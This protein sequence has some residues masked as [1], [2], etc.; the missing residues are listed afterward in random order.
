MVPHRTPCLALSRLILRFV[1]VVACLAAAS[2]APASVH[3]QAFSLSADASSIPIRTTLHLAA[4]AGAGAT[5]TV[6]FFDGRS[7]L[8]TVPLSAQGTAIYATAI[9]GSGIHSLGAVY[10]GDSSH[11]PT[12]A[13]TNPVSVTTVLPP[14]FTLSSNQ[15]SVYTGQPLTL[16]A[17]G[18]PPDATGTLT[19]LDAGVPIASTTISRTSA[20][21]YLS[22]GD[23]IPGGATLAQTALS[24]PSLLA[25][26]HSFSLTGSAVTGQTTCDVI[27]QQIVHGQVDFTQAGAPLTSLLSGLNDTSDPAIEP[28]FQLCHMAALAWLGVPREF[29][30]LPGDPGATVLS[31]NWTAVTDPADVSGNN[32]GTLYS[33]SPGTV[34]FALT[35]TGAPL[36]L[37]YLL[38]QSIASAFTLSVDGV[39]D[40]ATYNSQPAN[41]IN[42]AIG[43]G[44]ALLRIPV[45]PGP[46][47]VQIT[48]QSGNLGILA[49]GTPPSAADGSLH[50]TV[51][52]AE[53]PAENQAN[54]RDPPA[55][56]GRFASD[57][58]DD[59]ALLAADGLDL[60]LVALHNYMFGDPLAMS[61]AVHPNALGHTQ[62]AAAFDALLPGV[63]ASSITTFQPTTPAIAAT[64][65]QPGARQLTAAYSG[66]AV[67]AAAISEPLTQTVSDAS[68]SITL[69]VPSLQIPFDGPVILT[70]SVLPAS[71][72]GYVNFFANGSLLGYGVVTDGIASYHCALATGRWVLTAAFV[73]YA[74]QQPSTSAPITLTVAR[75]PASFS[76]S[77]QAQGVPGA[78]TSGIL[79]AYVDPVAA[80][81]SVTFTDAQT[82]LLATVPVLDGTAFLA[83][84][85]LTPGTHTYTAAYSGDAVFAPAS[86]PP[87]V[88]TVAPLATSLLATLT[89]MATTFGGPTSIHV[90]VLAPAV[91]LVPFTPSAFPPELNATTVFMGDSITNWWPLL[92]HNHGIA[93]QTTTQMLARFAGNVLNQGFERVVILGGANDILQGVDPA[94]TLANLS[95]MAAQAAAAGV[96]PIL[97]TLTPAFIPANDLSLQISSLNAAIRTLAAQSGYILLDYYPALAQHPELLLDGLHPNPGGYTRMETVLAQTLI[98]GTGSVTLND[99]TMATLSATGTA[100]LSSNAVP[101]GP[102]QLTVRYAGNA[103]LQAASATLQIT[104]AEATSST[105]LHAQ[106]L[107]AYAGN[108]VA[109]TATV[110]NTTP[111]TPTGPVS[112][113]DNG[114]PAGS[115]SLNAQGI[116]TFT[117]SNLAPGP[118]RFTASYAGDSN[119]TPSTSPAANLTSPFTNTTLALSAPAP[120]AVA[121][122]ALTLTAALTPATA[123]GSITLLDGNAVLAQI[124]LT[125]GQASYTTS[126]LALGAH[127]LTAVY[128]GD[129]DDSIASSPV[130]ALTIVPSPTTL[131]LA[132]LAS[133]QPV[134]SPTRLTASVT[135]ITAS[136]PVTFQDTYTAPNQTQAV[137]QAL[138]QGTLAAGSATITLPSLPV[139]VHVLS[140]AYAGDTNDLASTSSAQ[141]ITIT[142]LPSTTTLTSPQT[143][144]AYAT[145]ATFNVV[146]TPAAVGGVITLRDGN[147]A[148][149]A[150]SSLA[151][152]AVTFTLANLS[153]GLHTLTAAYAGDTNDQASTSAGLSI[154]V[155]PAPTSLTLAP[156]SAILAAGSPIS[157]NAAVAPSTASGTL[158]FRDAASGTL[159]QAAVTNGTATLTLPSLP[160]GTYSITAIYQGDALDAPSLSNTITTQI[161]LTPTTT[162]LLPVPDKLAYNKPLTLTASTSPTPASGSLSFLDNGSPL[163][164]AIL[165]NGAAT[166]QIPAL[167]IGT[168]SLYAS[169]AGNSLLAASISAS[170][171][172]R[173]AS[174]A[175]VTTLSLAQL[176]VVVGSP[177]T[178]NVQVNST[179]AQAPTGTVAIRS[180]SSILASGTL[181]HAQGGTSYATLIADSS[182]LAPGSFPVAAFYAGDAA[183]SPSDSSAVAAAF[184]IM[185]VPTGLTLQA[186]ATL[187]PAQAPTQIVATVTSAAPRQHQTPTGT[188]TFLL[189]GTAIASAPVD[190]S[191]TAAI[192]LPGQP[193]GTYT[194]TALYNPTGV[195]ASSTA[196]ADTL[197]FTPPL[198]LSLLHPS[199]AM[200]PNSS[201]LATLVI[202]P[203]SGFSGAI[204]S[205][206]T[207]SVPFLLCSVESPATLAGPADATIHLAVSTATAQRT[208]GAVNALAY[209][210]LLLLPLTRRLRKLS[211]AAVVIL[212][213][214]L[215][216]TLTGCVNG[217]DFGAIPSGPQVVT[218]TVTANQ[219]PAQIPLTI[220]VND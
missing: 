120:T 28:T 211:P 98:P 162:T 43:I 55:V 95:A 94:V 51:L 59:V 82:G 112:F 49:L 93:G 208:P 205:A 210:A 106:P 107:A 41:G 173:I 179:T 127:A 115:A 187:L 37:W 57:I 202:T 79:S 4:T 165:V 16:S 104:L 34:Q 153:V 64:L 193:V 197:T 151:N 156:L 61:D 109:F 195:F 166:L 170:A 161:V 191:G 113:L 46:H 30:V 213:A 9:L 68:T 146:V 116:A 77:A 124:P 84:A 73:P 203:L 175:T 194:L 22:L 163:G 147:G 50:P 216:S 152:G 56:S 131:V 14:A 53:L 214:G 10:W 1:S 212:L 126:S 31:G 183:D 47:V 11:T 209:A 164:S 15:A 136:G 177:I 178:F 182:L 71:S 119:F 138:G 215:A 141:T 60:R 158:T 220:Q 78:S 70:A 58:K 188:V 25:S 121:G 122:T 134:G 5:G 38:D 20:P 150:Q 69:S 54:P 45:A 72:V 125:A 75:R 117:A 160:P 6:T 29:K 103:S 167:S 3:A 91:P 86:S 189:N 8:A 90:D 21:S 148:V 80:T 111:A 155:S 88:L 206:C 2:L 108:A 199:L 207:S 135:P 142:P 201:A 17:H 87:A 76:F 169:F 66:N 129:A 219:T 172:T 100:T 27:A 62:L 23:D 33:R 81:G 26:E 40:S 74:G 118:H 168:H 157:L 198:S 143:T 137:V 85:D 176:N 102:Q 128:A 89:S 180:G 149:L 200:T 154:T 144:V 18:L 145:P 139:G 83:V 204:A 130:L 186:A 196:A 190:A 48:L 174:D 67:Y 92:L 192:T 63:S 65:Q 96:R 114:N 42:T 218:I 184:T 36:Y 132:P 97:A 35:T 171:L 12:F 105:T 101:A 133:A 39:P 159:G 99:G 7:P 181:S 110:T 52:A 123:T 140:A 32:Y 24:F 185:R 44:F 217:G 13:L 19:L